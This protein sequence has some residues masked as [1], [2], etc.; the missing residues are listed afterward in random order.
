MTRLLK[1][2]V[3]YG[4]ASAIALAVDAGVLFVLVHF[5]GWW[6][7]GAATV[8][9]AAGVVIT[10]LISVRLVFKHHRIESRHREFLAFVLIGV[11]GLA[12]NLAIMFVAVSLFGWNYM[13]GKGAAACGTFLCNFGL[14]RQVLFSASRVQA[15]GVELP[16]R[17]KA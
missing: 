10:Y 7:L 14:R 5:F 8:S 11:I 9:F 13:I 12:V 1:E 3:G 6:Y 17:R 16:S 15:S 2:A 4:L